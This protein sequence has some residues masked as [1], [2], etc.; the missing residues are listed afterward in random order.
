MIIGENNDEIEFPDEVIIEY[1]TWYNRDLDLGVEP[2]NIS[3]ENDELNIRELGISSGDGSL[4]DF[5]EEK[6]ESK[7]VPEYVAEFMISFYSDYDGYYK[8]ENTFV[9]GNKTYHIYGI[10][11]SFDSY[12]RNIR[13]FC[14]LEN[15]EL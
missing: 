15:G 14:T 6:Y 13:L 10:F 2:L 5:L 11:T 12:S 4:R 3:L 1:I 8:E 7:L 9:D